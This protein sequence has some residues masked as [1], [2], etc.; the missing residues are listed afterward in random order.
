MNLLVVPIFLL[1]IGLFRYFLELYKV[2]EIGANMEY[3]LTLAYTMGYYG[4][5]VDFMCIYRHLWLH[6]DIF[7][8]IIMV[9][10]E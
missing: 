1:L 10:Y 9:G 7:I 5:F 4:N 3:C 2:G 8:K 6:T